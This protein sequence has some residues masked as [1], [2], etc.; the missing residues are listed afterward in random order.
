MYEFQKKTIVQ[1][2]FM[3]D[4]VRKNPYIQHK[5]LSLLPS[6]PCLLAR[7]WRFCLPTNLVIEKLVIFTVPSPF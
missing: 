1:V 7:A 5:D 3:E 4:F 2:L 6:D